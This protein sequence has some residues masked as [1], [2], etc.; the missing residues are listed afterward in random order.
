MYLKHEVP[1]Y[2]HHDLSVYAAKAN[3]AL[4]GVV[5]VQKWVHQAH[6]LNCRGKSMTGA[7]CHLNKLPGAFQFVP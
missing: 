5:H 4:T 2:L 3:G 6:A 1:V 7:K